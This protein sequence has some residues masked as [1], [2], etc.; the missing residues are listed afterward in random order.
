MRVRLRRVSNAIRV[1]ACVR[2]HKYKDTSKNAQLI[3]H[4]EVNHEMPDWSARAN[5]RIYKSR[6]WK[7]IRLLLIRNINRIFSFFLVLFL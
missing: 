5:L 1:Y 3:F 2:G 7:F 6:R 4:I